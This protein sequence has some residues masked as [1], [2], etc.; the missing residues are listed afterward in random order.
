M[1]Q[2]IVALL[3]PLVRASS[4]LVVLVVLVVLL[5]VLLEVLAVL[6]V[7]VVLVQQPLPGAVGQ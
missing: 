1:P 2:D 7:L 3:L 4:V 6:A 5:E